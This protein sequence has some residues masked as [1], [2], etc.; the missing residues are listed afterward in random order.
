[1]LFK[2]NQFPQLKK[3]HSAGIPITLKKLEEIAK[4]AQNNQSHHLA[5]I[6]GV[7][8]SGKTL[9]GLQFVFES[10]MQNTK[11]KAVFL[12]G[13]GPLVDVLQFSLENRNFV[14]SVHGFLKEYS[15][16]NQTPS[17]DIIF[18]DE[19]QRAWDSEKVLGSKR[20]GNNAEPTDFIN[21]GN[22]K[23][24]CL[25]IGLIGEGQEIHLGEET[26]MALWS[27]A[28]NQ[29]IKKWIIHCP[30]KLKNIFPSSEVEVAA[31]FNLTTSLRTHQA[32]TLQR[33]VEELLD[34][35][36]SS[37]K[38]LSTK[39]FEEDYPIYVTRDLEKA[40][41]HVLI[42]YSTILLLV[43]EKKILTQEHFLKLNVNCGDR[44]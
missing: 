29:S 21:I 37:A 7:P 41:T 15:H 34:G 6:T 9:V 36:I 43:C 18:Y 27:E 8:G 1:M 2:E 14:Q 20:E 17:E 40:K 33:C 4:H 11:Q 24:H 44:R 26:G 10:Y 16:S 5:L 30:E 39:L 31:E 38:E 19:A 42:F 35:N 28:I 13:N 12:S 22:K 32:F 3:A 23:P 25:L